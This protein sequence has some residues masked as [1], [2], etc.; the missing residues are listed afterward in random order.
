M[1]DQQPQPNTAKSDL[2]VEIIGGSGNDLLMLHGW[3]QN[4]ESM[5]ALGELLS[6]HARVH[7]V[8]LPGFGRSPAP[9]E[10]WDTIGYAERIRQYLIDN[11]IERADMLGHSFGGRVSIRLSSRYPELVRS[12]TLINSGGLKRVQGKVK[13]K[14]RAIQMLGKTLKKIDKA[15]GSTSYEDWFVPKFA[16]VDYKNAGRLR[17]ILVKT[18]NEDV[19]ED[20]RKITAPVFLLWGELD[21]ETPVEMG[22]RFNSIIRDSKLVVLPGKGHFPFLGDSAHLCARYIIEFFKGLKIDAAARKE[23]A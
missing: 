17:N 6:K 11:N 19:T 15:F 1:T 14:S 12:V 7:L 5:R 9:S 23:E 4:L 22:Q 16:S 21:T 3:G 13:L 10:D 8:D 18:V 20:A 2:H